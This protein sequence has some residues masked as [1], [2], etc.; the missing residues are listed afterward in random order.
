MESLERLRKVTKRKLIVMILSAFL[1]LLI[2]VI[3]SLPLFCISDN[4]IFAKVPF[5]PPILCVAFE[6]YIIYKI[7]VHIRILKDDDYANEKLIIRNDERIRYIKLRCNALI[8]KTFFYVMGVA[9]IFAAFVDATV[10]YS[11]AFTLIAFLLIYLILF[12]FYSRKL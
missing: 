7:V 4:S 10:F 9:T 11:F 1:P 8:Q 6:A 2:V 3:F 5:L 12:S